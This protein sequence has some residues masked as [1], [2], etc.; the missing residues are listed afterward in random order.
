MNYEQ[1]KLRNQLCFRLYTASRL[2]TQSYEPMLKQLGITYTQYLVLMVLWE[3]D[4]LPI[5]SIGKKLMLGI[6][7][8]SPLIKRMEKLGIVARH[9]SESDRRQQFVYL[10]QKGKDMKKEAA[11]IPGCMVSMLDKC[12]VGMETINSMIPLLDE[13]IT[14]LGSKD[15]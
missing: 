11:K 7:T 12:G 2:I 1:L 5:N 10:T 3:E 8:T 15:K 13:F 9:S 14:K 6:N 4:H